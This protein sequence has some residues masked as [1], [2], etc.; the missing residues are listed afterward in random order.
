MLGSTVQDEPLATR[1]EGDVLRV[2]LNRPAKRNAINPA[3]RDRLLD[4][5]DGAEASGH[6]AILLDG[7]GPGFCAGADLQD[8]APSG[9]GMETTRV[10][11]ASTQR[12]VTSMLD[13]PV[14]VVAAVHGAAAGIGLTL[15]LAADV[16]VAAEDAR[17]IP[18]FVQRGLVPDGAVVNLLPR[19]IGIA[20]TKD[21]L[22]RGRP[23]SG[24]EAAAI[25]MIAVAV[26]P[27][28]L[29]STASSAA[30]ELAALP[31]AT[32]ALT[33]QMLGAA[34]EHDIASTLFAERMAQ[35]LATGT[36]DAAEGRASFFE[37]RPP[38]FRGR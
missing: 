15:A 6:R 19:L 22:M 27:S 35:G 8:S 21:F 5:F 29:E 24:G 9:P 16:C 31:T 7:A 4:V 11:R 37:R 1:V 18:A 2:T 13:C 28:A 20:R 33:K 12:L 34:F 26:A 3:L 30:A 32:L 38:Q 14:P 10:M 25:G 17:F 23:L 36:E